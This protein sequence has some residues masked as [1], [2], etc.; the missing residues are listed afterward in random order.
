MVER[1]FV[2]AE[3]GVDVGL[4]GGTVGVVV[5]VGDVWP[6]TEDLDGGAAVRAFAGDDGDVQRIYRLLARRD[7][8]SGRPSRAGRRP[9]AAA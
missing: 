5:D 8:T 3:V 6:A 1:E 4:V 9:S 7:E 2:F